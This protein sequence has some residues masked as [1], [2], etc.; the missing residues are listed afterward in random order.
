MKKI[1][2]LIWALLLSLVFC[3]LAETAEATLPEYDG[4]LIIEDGLPQPMLNYTDYMDPYVNQGDNDVLRFCVYVETDNDTDNDGMADLVKVLVQLPRSA[5][6]GVYKA[7]AIYDPTPYNAGTYQ[8]KDSHNSYT[9]LYVEEPFNYN[10]LYRDCE[11]R[12][13][14]GV[15]T[16][17]EAAQIADPNEWI[18]SVP[19][20]RVQ[21][22]MY[23]QDY[24]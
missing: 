21:G 10:D 22:Y 20:S 17:L 6:E 7:A 4:N 19:I 2:I 18:Y 11:K 12:T 9:S 15:V 8:D 5:A 13:P 16:T 23:A 1:A 24:D 3:G 14:E